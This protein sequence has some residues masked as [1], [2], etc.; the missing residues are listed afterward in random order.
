[1]HF[2]KDLKKIDGYNQD[3]NAYLA[4]YPDS[5][6]ET[7]FAE[8]LKQYKEAADTLQG[9]PSII[10]QRIG[11]VMIA[12]AAAIAVAAVFTPVPVILG[13]ASLVTALIGFGMFYVNCQRTGLSQ[14]A[15]NLGDDFS[16]PSMSSAS[17]TS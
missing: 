6:N 4:A 2:E 13:A 5:L 7:S 14:V 11:L 16:M 8:A 10:G 3:M 15:K 17:S 12:I 9:S 1:M